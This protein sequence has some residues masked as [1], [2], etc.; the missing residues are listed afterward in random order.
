MSYDMSRE[1]RRISTEIIVGFVIRLRVSIF[2]LCNVPLNDP[3][4]RS[5]SRF[6]CTPRVAAGRERSKPSLQELSSFPEVYVCQASIVSAS[7][8]MEFGRQTILSSLKPRPPLLLLRMFNRSAGQR[9]L[10]RPLLSC[11]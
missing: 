3:S 9:R 11:G 4:Q 1:I 8:R 5:Y 10:T 2:F 6:D 7:Q